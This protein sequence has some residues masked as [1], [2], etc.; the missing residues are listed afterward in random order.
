MPYPN[1][2]GQQFQRE[3]PVRKYQE[4]TAYRDVDQPAPMRT[5]NNQF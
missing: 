5:S 1:F 3:K 4:V 2:E